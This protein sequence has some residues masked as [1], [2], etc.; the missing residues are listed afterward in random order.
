MEVSSSLGA[1]TSLCRT[2]LYGAGKQR[3]E[4]KRQRSYGS[5]ER[6]FRDGIENKLSLTHE[7]LSPKY[8][9]IYIT[10]VGS[11]IEKGREQVNDPV[12]Y[13]EGSLRSRGDAK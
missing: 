5:F 1:V 13:V 6:R 10:S 11:S 2:Y 8:D 7:I 3:I 12:R 4:S 9:M